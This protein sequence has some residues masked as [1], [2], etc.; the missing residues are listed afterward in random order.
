MLYFQCLTRSTAGH[1]C[2]SSRPTGQPGEGEIRRVCSQPNHAELEILDRKYIGCFVFEF[3]IIYLWPPISSTSSWSLCS[4]PTATRS[5]PAA[6]RKCASLSSGGS[7]SPVA[8]SP[9][10]VV[11]CCCCR[12]CFVVHHFDF[13]FRSRKMCSILCATLA[14]RQTSSPILNLCPRKLSVPSI[15]SDSS[16][17]LRCKQ[18]LVSFNHPLSSQFCKYLYFQLP[19]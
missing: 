2:S 19:N 7:T 10:G 3:V 6:S 13:L 9:S 4:T 8:S 11:S 17:S 18:A 14:P 12:H 16:S 5:R 15:G 1:R